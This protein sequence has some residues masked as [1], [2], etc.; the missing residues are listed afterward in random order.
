MFKYLFIIANPSYVYFNLFVLVCLK[1][2]NYSLNYYLVL[3]LFVQVF[4]SL[5]KNFHNIHLDKQN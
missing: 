3:Y 1:A 5:G 2:K 4:Y